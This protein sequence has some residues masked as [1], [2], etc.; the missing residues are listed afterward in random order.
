MINSKCGMNISSIRDFLRGIE[1]TAKDA[2]PARLPDLWCLTASVAVL[3]HCGLEAE[4]REALRPVLN[5]ADEVARRRYRTPECK[6][7]G[8]V[9]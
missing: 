7:D 1:E 6:D 9:S 3:A 5:L 8:R 2:E 4:A